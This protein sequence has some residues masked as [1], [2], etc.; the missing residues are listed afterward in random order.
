MIYAILTIALAAAIAAAF[1]YRVLW[2]REYADV[3][4]LDRGASLVFDHITCGMISKSN[5]DPHIVIAVA[6]DASCKLIDV[7]IEEQ[8]S[9][10]LLKRLEP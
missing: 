9:D 5:T 8:I 3:L 6:D 7:A 2:R 1:Y 10:G 4:M